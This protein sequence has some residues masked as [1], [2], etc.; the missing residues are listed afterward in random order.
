VAESPKPALR[1]K[2]DLLPPAS[3]VATLMEASCVRVGSVP[4][5][6]CMCWSRRVAVEIDP[7]VAAAYGIQNVGKRADAM[8]ALK[9]DKLQTFVAAAEKAEAACARH[10]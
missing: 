4:M 6:D 10:S 8:T 3:P 7:E 9:P 2:Q 1:P 5:Q